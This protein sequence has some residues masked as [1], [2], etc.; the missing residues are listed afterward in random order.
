[1]PNGVDDALA[2]QPG[3]SL[4]SMKIVK[5]GGKVVTISGDQFETERQITTEQITQLPE[6]QRELAT[7]T[8]KVAEG[9]IRMSFRMK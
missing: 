4:T 7:L 5:D 9:R 2:I 6:I 8:T 3:T 1:M